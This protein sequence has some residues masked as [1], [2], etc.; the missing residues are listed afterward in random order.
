MFSG[1]LVPAILRILPLQVDETGMREEDIKQNLEIPRP[2]YPSPCHI[3]EINFDWVWPAEQA[4]VPDQSVYYLGIASNSLIQ[5]GLVLNCVDAT[6]ETF[7]RIGI[8]TLR[9]SEMLGQGE[10]TLLRIV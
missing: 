5:Y 2:G 4:R 10:L 3:F 7:E 1:R 9:K 6:T 8:A